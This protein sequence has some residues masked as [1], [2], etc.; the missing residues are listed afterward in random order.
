MESL[1]EKTARGLLWGGIAGGATQLLNALFGIVLGRLLSPADY[2]MVAMLTIFSAIA[3]ALQEGGFISAL[4]KRKNVTQ[5][6]Y[7]SVFWF[8]V[9]VSLLIYVI[10]FF[11]AP[12]IARF[13]HEPALVPLSRFVFLGFFISTLNIVPRAYLFR[14]LR[15]KQTTV[16]S[17]VS[18]VIS[19]V[20]GIVMAAAGMAYWGLAVQSVVFVTGLTV[21][22]YLL[23]RWHPSLHFSLRPIR[24]MFGFSGLLIVTNIFTIVNA[25]LFSILLGR[26]YGKVETGNFSQGNKWNSMGSTLITQTLQGVAQPVFAK[27][28]DEGQLLAA[29]RKLLRFTACLTFPAMLGMSLVAG[30]FIR[31]TLGSHWDAAAGILRLLCVWGAFVPLQGLMTNLLI[32]RGRSRI[33]M[34]GTILLAVASLAVALVMKPYGMVPMLRV[35]VGLNILWTF[36][37][38]YFV[39]RET[40]LTLWQTLRDLSPYF[41]LSLA[42]AAGTHFATSFLSNIWA[43]FFAKVILMGT[44][45]CLVL[46]LS[47][48]VIFRESVDY[49]LKRKKSAK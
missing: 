48:S 18:L 10:L 4:N 34:W 42:L 29:F 1:K 36:F 25:N 40:G 9:A 47:G 20:A 14:E 2:G 21:G 6:D 13:Y 12:L 15:V 44:L 3:S 19:G 11:C 37:W 43:A 28:D 32:A 38:Q 24:E 41:L 8:N 35:F 27:I 5:E 23:T 45:Y 33:Y 17:L 22:S 16:L 49:L 39:G 31:I 7:N 30:E 46:H 26:F